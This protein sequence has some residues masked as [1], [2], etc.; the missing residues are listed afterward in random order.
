LPSVVHEHIN[1]AVCFGEIPEVFSFTEDGEMPICSLALSLLRRSLPSPGLLLSL[2]SR[3]RFVTLIGAVFFIIS[4]VLLRRVFHNFS[5]C[6]HWV[7]LYALYL[8]F[9]AK[10]GR[11]GVSSWI[12]A[13]P[14]G[15]VCYPPFVFYDVHDLSRL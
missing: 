2:W 11:V 6:G 14:V 15:N 13:L 1:D 9:K 3:D 12:L 7:L 8:F 4:P 5:L 10:N